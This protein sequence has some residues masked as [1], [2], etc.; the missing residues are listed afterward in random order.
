[1]VGMEAL[2]KE[3]PN[4]SETVFA[5]FVVQCTLASIDWNLD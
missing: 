4:P 3:A 2:H 5:D 1:M